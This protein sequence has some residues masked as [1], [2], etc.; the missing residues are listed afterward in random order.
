MSNIRRL[1]ISLIVAG[2][3]AGTANAATPALTAALLTDIPAVQN[4][5]MQVAHDKLLLDIARATNNA[6]GITT[7]WAHLMA[8][9]STLKIANRTL[10]AD[11]KMYVKPSKDEVSVAGT[12][13]EAA[14]VQLKADVAKNN[15][16]AIAAD[17][18]LVDTTFTALLT[19]QMQLQAYLN[20]LAGAGAN[21]GCT[22]DIHGDIQ[23]SG[24]H[25]DD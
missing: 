21:E 24:R 8:D 23:N 1:T 6:A 13:F 2:M 16:A 15:T 19:A 7:N 14:F 3:V 25:N 22:V 11:V 4:A 9:M 12:A 20:A 5:C 18:K 10:A 17:T